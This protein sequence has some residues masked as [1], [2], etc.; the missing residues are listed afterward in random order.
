MR[1]TLHSS[2]KAVR[3][4]SPAVRTNGASNGAAVDTTAD[5]FQVAML[6]V[7]SGAMTDGSV[8]VTAEDS[9]NGSTGWTAVPAERR[10]GS[11]PTI[12]DTDDDA[13]FEVGVV[14]DPLR[15]YLRAVATVSG[16]TSG[17]LT[18]AVFLLG[19]PKSYPIAR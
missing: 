17:G 2:T 14:I 13:V 5:D 15:P 6:V 4:L 3:T 16:A 1:Q 18:S 9:A 10:Q 12:A 7:S 8:A 19:M 11:L